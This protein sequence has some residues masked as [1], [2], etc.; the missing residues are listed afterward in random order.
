MQ[1]QILDFT[2]ARGDT[3]DLVLKCTDDAGTIV[4]LT[5]CTAVMS[6]SAEKA[7]TGNTYVFQSIAAVDEAGGILTFPFIEE[8]MDVLGKTYYDVQVTDADSKISTILKGVLTFVQD[9]TK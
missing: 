7:P 3:K 4:P 2:R 5:A 1:P 6:V 9:I 8:E